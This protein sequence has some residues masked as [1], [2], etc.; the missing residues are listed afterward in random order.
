ML[1]HSHGQGTSTSS[2]HE[3]T[4]AT[5]ESLS[6]YPAAASSGG[7]RSPWKNL[8]LWSPLYHRRQRALNSPPS[9]TDEDNTEP[10]STEA[11]ISQP[12]DS[13]EIPETPAAAVDNMRH[14]EEGHSD[15]GPATATASSLPD[16]CEKTLV[17][18]NISDFTIAKV[19][20]KRSG[21]SG[22]EYK[23]EFQP[24]WWAALSAEAAQMGCVHIR[25]YENK[26]VR[27]RRL[28]TLRKRKFSQV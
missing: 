26:L 2:S 28:E 23:C 18:V 17:R 20:D 4:H 6:P 3:P 11:L 9:E 27:S 19:I 13:S 7:K 15:D 25:D 16:L 24:L 8:P 21:P 1:T 10:F 5:H 22:V 12:K 14:E